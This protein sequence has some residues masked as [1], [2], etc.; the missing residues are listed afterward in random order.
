MTRQQRQ[1]IDALLRADPRDPHATVEDM[2]AGFVERQTVPLPDDVT[3][4][5]VDLGGVPALE[6]TTPG[7]ADGTLLYLHGGGYVVGSARTGAHLAVAVGRRAG[8]RALSL[9]YRLAPEHPF[10]AAVEDGVAAY[11]ALL[12][13]GVRPDEVVLAGDSAGGGLTVATL[14]AAR[15]AGLPMPAAAVVFSPF[16]DLALEG[17]SLR[18]QADRDPLF[19][20]ER[21]AVY[22]DHYVSEQRRTDPLASPIRADL[23]GL[24]PLL[25]QVGQNEVILDDAVRLAGRA[26][27]DG[28][29]VTLEV[30]PDVPHVFQLFAGA[31]DDA[32]DALDRAGAFLRGH[33]PA[34]VAA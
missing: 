10:P 14:V 17:A 31:L 1:A 28:V 2:R 21:L 9:D 30:W 13:G 24:P 22:V 18:T 25:V 20:R 7:V 29:A 3:A 33:L 19:T 32:D 15:D 11:R 34:R 16:T 27:A 6:L 5:P 8:V 12:D 23:T 26:G 4:R